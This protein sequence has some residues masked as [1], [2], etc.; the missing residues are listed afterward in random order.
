[1]LARRPVAVASFAAKHAATISKLCNRF[2]EPPGHFWRNLSAV[3][4]H[5]M[6]ES[7]LACT[8]SITIGPASPLNLAKKVSRSHAEVD[9]NPMTTGDFCGYSAV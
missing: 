3:S 8:A 4:V 7:V 2:T 9:Q 5:L 1:M 6:D